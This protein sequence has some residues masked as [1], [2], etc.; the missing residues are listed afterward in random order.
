MTL[1]FIQS[2]HHLVAFVP[3]SSNFLICCDCVDSVGI[4]DEK[5]ANGRQKFSAFSQGEIM[6][7][8]VNTPQNGKMGVL[9]LRMGLDF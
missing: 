9:L 3:S 1:C 7:L 4:F 8:L 6:G 5:A 2:V